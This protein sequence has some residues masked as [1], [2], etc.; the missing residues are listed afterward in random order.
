MVRL[1]Q[2]E[3]ALTALP[4]E[5]QTVLHMVAVEGLSYQDAATRSAFP[6]AR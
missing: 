1:H 3:A 5:Q 6:S 2:I 4:E